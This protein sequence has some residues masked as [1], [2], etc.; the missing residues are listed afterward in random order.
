MP[1]GRP[2]NP[3]RLLIRDLRAVLLAEQFDLSGLDELLERGTPQNVVGDLTS[4][5]QPEVQRLAAG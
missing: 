3:G 2:P 1:V 5:S 4:A